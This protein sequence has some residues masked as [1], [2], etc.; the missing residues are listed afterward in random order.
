M[1]KRRNMEIAVFIA[2]AIMIN[3]LGKTISI[4]YEPLCKLLYQV[5]FAILLIFAYISARLGLGGKL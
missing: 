3:F 1:K 2:A 4:S 5:R